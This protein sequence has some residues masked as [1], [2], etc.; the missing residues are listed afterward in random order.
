M[1]LRVGLADDDQLVRS[2]LRALISYEPDM[3]VVG[4]AGDGDE[5]LKVVAATDPDLV[6]MDIRMPNRDGLSATREIV[7]RYAERDG[8]G[9][10]VLMLTTFELDEYVYE[11]LQVGA[12]GFMLK[13]VPPDE[14]LDAIR[15]VASGESL[16]F[17]A[18]TRQLVETSGQARD[19]DGL[20]ATL[21]DR[22]REVLAELA[23]GS[24]NAEIAE[25]L[26]I[27]GE[28]VKSHVANVLVK[29][30]VRD[31][32]HAV[33]YAYETGFTQPRD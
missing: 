15:F 12:S 33:I 1:T 13:R 29:L 31:R 5:A 7:A 22:E 32:V 19:D 18:L 17:P 3:E 2:G 8:G 26:F 27:G 16:V 6:L 10:K 24:S 11:A 23:R 9:P 25:S 28:T 4:E 14:L 21:T 20:L 30:G